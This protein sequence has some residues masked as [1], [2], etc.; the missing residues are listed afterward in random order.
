MKLDSVEPT[1]AGTLVFREARGTLSRSGDAARL[2]GALIRADDDAE[3]VASWLGRYGAS[4]N[5]L[6]AARKEGERWLLWLA[7][8]QQRLAN[9]TVEDCTAYL[10]FLA[11]PQ[12]P[13]RWCGP[14]KPRHLP[15]GAPNPAWRPLQGPLGRASIAQSRALVHGLYEYL[16]AAR[17]LAANPWRLLPRATNP[18]AASVDD[19]QAG[20]IERFLPRAAVDAVLQTVAD[21]AGGTPAEQRHAARCR[22]VFVLLFLTGARRSE[23]VAARMGHIR[24]V[25]GAWWWRVLGKGARV[26]TIPLSAEFMTELASYRR[27][28]GLAT[29]LPAPGEDVPLVC[30]VW[31]RKA[32]I[33]AS[34]L[35]KLV[36][37]TLA[38]AADRTAYDNPQLAAR[39]RAASTHWLRHTAATEQLNTA[40]ADLV[41]VQRNLRHASVSTTSRYLHAEEL[42]RHR[43][44]TEH[45]LGPSSGE[46][47][48]G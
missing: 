12:P 14:A 43:Q 42:E 9:V 21:F 32:P 34:A 29:A 39:L 45:R 8:R 47:P 16:A 33:T 28:L 26:G 36:K 3:A 44:T 19:P 48:A 40:G 7:D 41:V 23:V 35:Y 24:E 13:E 1:D 6:A 11:N 4:P 5:T 17:W 46:T 31:G 10:A 18:A 38:A 25:N 15:D 30:D 37:Q 22:W 27:H 2:N 20:V